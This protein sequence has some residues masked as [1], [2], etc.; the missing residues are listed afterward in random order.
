MESDSLDLMH[1]LKAV[2]L[3]AVSQGD[4]MGR[5]GDF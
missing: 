2:V 4:A 3:G 5:V 1:L